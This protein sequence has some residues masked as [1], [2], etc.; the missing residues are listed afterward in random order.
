M[1]PGTHLDVYT[2]GEAMLRLSVAPGDRLRS[3]PAYDVNVGGSESNV[4]MALARL[5]RTVAWGSRLPSNELGR[6]VAESVA[7][8]GVDVSGVVWSDQARLGTYFVELRPPPAGPMVIYDRAGSAASGL[9]FDHL[10]VDALDT[11]RWVHVTGITPALSADCRHATE[12]A[13][14]HVRAR[15]GLVSLDVNY[16]ARLW[17]PDDARAALDRLAPSTDLVLCSAEDAAHV[18]QV[19]G[20]PEQVVERLA[21]RWSC[22]R[23]VLTNGADGVVWIDH[24]TIGATPGIPTPHIVDRIGAGDALAAGVIHGALDGDLTAGVQL[25]V[26]MSTITL[27]TRGDAY[28]GTLAEA[29]QLAHHPGR[30]IDR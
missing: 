29:E 2:F 1:S 21:E 12:R 11:A 24:G 9:T 28:P 3:A 25:G 23:V 5:G 19:S 4:A 26:A 7:A 6:R 8:A 16:R 10:S 17:G 27:G 14:A 18:F 30:S 15:G 13:V 22:P 20:P